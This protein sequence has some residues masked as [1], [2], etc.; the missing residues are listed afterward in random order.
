MSEVNLAKAKIEIQSNGLKLSD[1]IA[2]ELQDRFHFFA[3]YPSF[4]IR[5]MQEKK[6]KGKL[7]E[8]GIPAGYQ[9]GRF[10][11]DSYLTID[12]V[13]GGYAI[14]KNGQPFVEVDFLPKL[15]YFENETS[16]GVSMAELGWVFVPST[17][18][19]YVEQECMYW[20]S[21]TQCR[22]CNTENQ[23]F[24]KR[25]TP[26]Q[27]VETVAAGVEEGAID[28]HIAITTGMRPEPDNG[29]VPMVEVVKALKENFDIPISANVGPPC[30]DEGKYIGMLNDAGAD[31]IYINIEAYDPKAR[32]MS[33]PSKGK[34]TMKTYEKA[35]N[36]AIDTFPENQVC[37]VLLAGLGESDESIF[38]G[39]RYIAESGVLPFLMPAFPAEGSVM[40]G[41]HPP[42]HERMEMLYLGVAE[43]LK[44]NG[45]DPFKTKAGLAHCGTVSALKE[46]LYFG[47]EM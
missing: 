31:S 30:R 1:E 38:E 34:I 29:I 6:L 12:K 26:E 44:E 4:F 15:H 19:T 2:E 28:E 10:C 43:I 11:E 13:N 41:Q 39:A 25:K 40:D 46:A 22:F 24:L 33:L 7:Y 27:I 17:Y 20:R 21:G 32:E 14:F 42:S 37:S 45:V 8:K 23:P 18:V 35:W 47:L 36:A 5:Q 16:D 3:G 9:Y